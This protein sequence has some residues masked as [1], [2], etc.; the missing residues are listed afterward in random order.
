MVDNIKDPTPHHIFGGRSA[1]WLFKSRSFFSFFFSS[2]C[3]LHHASRLQVVLAIKNMVLYAPCTR[4][5][6]PCYLAEIHKLTMWEELFCS[7]FKRRSHSQQASF[8]APCSTSN[9]TCSLN[10]TWFSNTAADKYIKQRVGSICKS[11]S[12]S[13]RSS[14]FHPNCC[15]IRW[16]A[17]GE[18]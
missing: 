8:D 10:A 16:T 15:C 9:L 5:L 2:F 12:S 1:T 7:T 14:K 6:A 18:H 3:F 17:E 4:S 11:W 13:W